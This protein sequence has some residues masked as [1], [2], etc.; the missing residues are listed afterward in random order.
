MG[1][2]D[3]NLGG[4]LRLDFVALGL[5][6]VAKNV[7][8][9]DELGAFIGGEGLDGGAGVTASAANH[10]D[11]ERIRTGGIGASAQF[12]RADSGG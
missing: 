11:L 8:H 2:I 1:V 3:G 10:A 9:G 7:T 4:A 6:P 12:Q 5:N